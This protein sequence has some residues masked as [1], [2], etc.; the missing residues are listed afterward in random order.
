MSPSE[1]EGKGIDVC[2]AGEPEMG[3]GKGRSETGVAIVSVTAG[4][5]NEE[6]VEACIVASRSG[7]G[8]EAGAK[9]PH[10]KRKI[11]AVIIQKSFILFIIQF[12]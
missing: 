2:P 11:S 4:E 5:E 12:N 10:P 9:S 6:G 3:L 1:G 8:E 7:V